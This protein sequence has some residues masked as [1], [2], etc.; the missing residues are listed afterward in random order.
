[1]KFCLFIDLIHLQ[2][3]RDRDMLIAKY[4]EAKAQ[5]TTN[6]SQH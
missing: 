4:K 5:N 1:M 6:Y 3:R 2:L